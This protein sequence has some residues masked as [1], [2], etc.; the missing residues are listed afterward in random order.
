MALKISNELRDTIGNVMYPVGSVYLSTHS[1]NPST[2]F[3]GSWIRI[4]GATNSLVLL[5][6][7]VAS[8]AG[9]IVDPGHWNSGSTSIT[10]AQMAVHTHPLS[11]RTGGGGGTTWY[12]DPGTATGFNTNA[13]TA[14][15]NTGGGQG[16]THNITPPYFK[17]NVWRRT[18]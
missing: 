13:A 17:V 5:G 14:I 10:E 11:Y 8:D 2:L 7:K 6:A 16:H 1:T 4:E 15:G 9:V 3:G 18:V 12:T